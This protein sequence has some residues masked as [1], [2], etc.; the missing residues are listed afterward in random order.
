MDTQEKRKSNLKRKLNVIPSL[1][2][3]KNIMIV[4]D[5]IVRGNTMNHIIELLRS[6]Y[7]GKITVISASTYSECK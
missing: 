3:G 7:V 5:S 2:A 4:D 1:I 6:T